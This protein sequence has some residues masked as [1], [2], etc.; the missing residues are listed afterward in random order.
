MWKPNIIMVVPKAFR[1]TVFAVI[2]H[3]RDHTCVRT[4]PRVLFR[5]NGHPTISDPAC[6]PRIR[7]WKPNITVVVRKA[8]RTT[9][10]VVIDHTLDHSHV[11]TNSRVQLQHLFRLD[12]HPTISRPFELRLFPTAQSVHHAASRAAFDVHHDG[13]TGPACV[14]GTPRRSDK[15]HPPLF[16]STSRL[17][18]RR[19]RTFWYHGSPRVSIPPPD[20]ILSFQLIM[21]TIEPL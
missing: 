19:K 1:T 9:I 17:R 20:T 16:Y 2:N 3:T 21:T 14:C 5:L 12:G 11:Q 10:F 6:S 15:P 13:R 8:F 4:N 18:N 7:I